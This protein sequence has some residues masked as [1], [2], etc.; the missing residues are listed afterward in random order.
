MIPNSSE[1]KQ[2]A[3]QVKSD[4]EAYLKQGGKI[5]EVPVLIRDGRSKQWSGKP[6]N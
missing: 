5:E 1:H 3:K 6:I 4:V 2:K